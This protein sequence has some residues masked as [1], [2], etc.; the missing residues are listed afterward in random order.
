MF[1]YRQPGTGRIREMGLGSLEEVGLGDARRRADEARARLRRGLDPQDAR[2]EARGSEGAERT[3]IFREVAELVLAQKQL[4]WKSGK[5]AKQWRATLEAH[6]YPVIG[7]LPVD[8]IDTEH[9]LVVLQPLWSRTPETASRLRQRLETVLAAAAALGLR[10]RTRIN[11]ASWRGHLQTLLPPPRRLRPVRHFP[12]LPWQQAPAFY[13]EL[14]RREGIA[15]LT[16]RFCMLTAQRSGA[17]RL[18]RWSEIDEAARVWTSPAAHMKAARP[19]RVPLTEAMLAVLS[20]V[21]PL[22]TGPDGLIF[23]GARS[24]RP[25]SDMA[26]SMLVRGL[27]CDGL[28]PGSLPRWRDEDG[29][30]VTA[31][32]LRSTF[33][34]WCRAHGVEEHVAEAALAHV[35]RDR[36][37]AAYARG[38]VLKQRRGVMERWGEFCLGGAVVGPG[39]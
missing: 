38:D 13:A 17:V 33:R 26:L 20:A 15:A 39:G 3:P 30:A 6:A 28:E 9:V 14:C 22:A 8:R 37:R 7:A 12:A 32:G 2:R 36:V 31:H 1:R 21:R 18:A 4:G 34:E 11:P 24:G 27:C 23:P 5:H 35:D 10:D 19:H 25:L 29:R 16:V